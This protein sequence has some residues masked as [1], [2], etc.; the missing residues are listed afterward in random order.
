MEALE[1]I[2]PIAE[3]KLFT[4]KGYFTIRR[5]D[6]F[7]GG[8]FSDQT[9]EQFLMRMLKTSG[10]MTHGRGI[11]D[12]TLTKWVHALPRCVPICDAL[13]QFTGV[14]TGTSEQHKDMQQSTQ[15]RDNRDRCIFVEWL[16][17]HPPFAGY[18]PDRLVSLSTGIVADTSV[19]CDDAVEIGRAAASEMAGKKFTDITL[20]RND[21]VKTIGAQS[22]TVKVRGQNT[23]VNP[24]LLFNRITCVL[25]NSSEM[26]SFLAYELAPQ[27]PSL[28]QGGVMRKPT[29]SSL[30][31]LLKSFTQQSNLPENCLFVLDGGHLLQSV[32]WP[33]PSTYAGVYQ[34]YIS[35][36]LKHYG[37]QSTVVFDGYGST[38]STKVAEQRRR[39]QKC[40]SSDIIFEDNMPTTTT[41]AA[42]LANSNNIKRLTQT[43]HEKMLMAGIQYVSSRLKQ[44]QTH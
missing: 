17:A 37:A 34:S 10:G 41:Q 39:A 14:H 44:T 5:Q 11:T 9:I 29:K 30:G 16:Q 33:Q 25:N 24:S 18:E 7:W 3:Y 20:R 2:M 13:E 28:F 22:K 15:S 43:L 32:V 23:E 38:T 19:N 1:Q 35:Y 31:L 12:S 36:I 27:P 6:S 26:G 8:N 42:F 21:K 4:E 40:T